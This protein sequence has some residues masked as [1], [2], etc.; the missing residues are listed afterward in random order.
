MLHNLSQKPSTER[1]LHASISHLLQYA[2]HHLTSL[3]FVE[4]KYCYK[5]IDLSSS[6]GYSSC[7][8]V[9]DENPSY[10]RDTFHFPLRVGGPFES[11]L[12]WSLKK[13][14]KL[15]KEPPAL[16][17]KRKSVPT[18]WGVFIQKNHAWRRPST[19]WKL[20]VL[21]TIF[22]FHEEEWFHTMNSR[23]K[24]MRYSCMQA[25]LRRKIMW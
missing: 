15:P 23:L 1:G 22:P 24:K 14:N 19:R 10:S 11:L 6:W 12:I 21:R 16:R 17:R 25:S 13:I 7:M 18:V 9:L 20:Y 2:L 8:S 5:H 4:G 3:F